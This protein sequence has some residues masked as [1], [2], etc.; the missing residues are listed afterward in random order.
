M[1]RSDGTFL[2]QLITKTLNNI[3]THTD[4]YLIGIGNHPTPL[5]TEEVRTLIKKTSTFSGGK[6]HYELVK[7]HLPQNHSWIEISGKM[8]VVIEAYK[9]SNEPVM[10]FT[11]GDP[12]FYGFGNTLQ[13]YLPEAAVQSFPY[14]NS[15]QRLCQKTQTNYND[16]QSVSVHGRDWSALDTALISD[17]SL[18]GV[19]TDGKKTPTEISK[20]LLQ[21]GFDNYQITVG[22]ELDGD[23][24]IIESHQLE[25]CTQ[26]DYAPL[27]CILLKKTHSKETPFGIPDD[28]FIP[29]DNRPNMITKMPIRL[30]TLQALQLNNASTFWDIGSCTGS[31]AIEAKRHFPHLKVLAFEKREVC[32]SIIQKNTEQLSS[33]GIEIIIDDFFNLDLSQYSCPDVIFIGG[34][35]NRLKEMI[36]KIHAL[37]PSVRMVTN[38]VQESSS[39][40]FIKELG[41]LNYSIDTTT[42]QVDQHNKISIHA[43]K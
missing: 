37:N 25:A 18:I 28:Q 23:K 8:D 31:V 22:E 1:P 21:Y 10:I 9:K 38:A 6:R 41:Q 35:G 33:P 42:L 20:R 3:N 43:T 12:F 14:F 29:L 36:H 7:T 11:S 26:L 15:I 17:L 40:T 16:L 30:T 2:F 4:F 39:Q 34:H 19:L 24:E 13:R 32:K 5:L 27:N